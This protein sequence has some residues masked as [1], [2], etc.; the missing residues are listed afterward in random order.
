MPT[1]REGRRLSARKGQAPAKNQVAE[2]RTKLT[3]VLD[4][5]E[6]EMVQMQAD[7][8][9]TTMSEV[10]RRAL[11]YYCAVDIQQATIERQ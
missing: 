3:L 9:H 11:R 10:T 4:D 8:E 7:R 2:G 6:K 5:E 1:T